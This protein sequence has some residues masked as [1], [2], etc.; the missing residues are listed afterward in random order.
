[1]NPHRFLVLVALSVVVSV[2]GAAQQGSTDLGD[3]PEIFEGVDTSIVVG[4][5]ASPVDV[6][7]A[8]GIAGSLGGASGNTSYGFSVDGGV[9][10][11]TARNDLRF[12]D[13]LNEYT[14][15]VTSSS[16]PA[17]EKVSFS[18]GSV[19]TSIEHRLYPSPNR[20]RFGKPDGREDDDP[21]VH[22]RNPEDPDTEDY[23]FRV[24]AEFGDGVDLTSRDL[25]G[26]QVPLFGK[27][28][29]VSG[30]TTD[31]RLVWRAPVTGCPCRG[32]IRRRSPSAA[33]R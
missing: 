18:E 14:E 11:S 26:E 22:V 19:D 3:Y 1:M 8:V 15:A 9:G 33:R 24:R 23:L 17:L 25:R 6:A 10:L 28:R 13:P 7:G 30:E 32:Q 27:E 20:V 2:G 31:D 4:E 5:D 29:T 16:L 21:V 12:G